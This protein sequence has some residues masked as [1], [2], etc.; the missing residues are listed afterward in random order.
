MWAVFV[1]NATGF[2]M[3]Q[4]QSTHFVAA[5]YVPQMKDGNAKE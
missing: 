2:S 5:R 4:S 1:A 3:H